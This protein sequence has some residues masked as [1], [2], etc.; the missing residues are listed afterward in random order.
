MHL[1]LLRYFSQ[2]TNKDLLSFFRVFEKVGEQEGED[3]IEI[4]RSSF[5]TKN[6]FSIIGCPFWDGNEFQQCALKSQ[7]TRDQLYLGA[8]PNSNQPNYLLVVKHC[9]N[10]FQPILMYNKQYLLAKEAVPTSQDWK[11]LKMN[12]AFDRITGNQLF[13]N[14]KS[15]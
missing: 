2:L 3:K 8:N 7:P 1:S 6:P 4:M 11:S 13:L 15:H 5:K 12:Y 9:C 14:A 10:S